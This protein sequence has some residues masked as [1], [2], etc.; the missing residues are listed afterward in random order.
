[1]GGWIGLIDGGTIGAIAGGRIAGKSSALSQSCCCLPSTKVQRH[2]AEACVDTT[3]APKIT[4]SLANFIVPPALYVSHVGSENSL[5]NRPLPTA[6][7]VCC[8]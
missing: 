1:M 2:S 4:T 6:A 5:T 7:S 8:L 3:T